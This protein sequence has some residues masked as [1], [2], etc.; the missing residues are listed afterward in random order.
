MTFL[1][2]SLLAGTALVALPIV[3]HLI[4]R[5][6]PRHLEFPALRFLETRRQTNQRQL[7]LRHLLLLALRVAAIFFLAAALA[8][9]SVKFSGALGSQ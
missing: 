2:A 5:R 8:R 4:M 1:N 6:K 9:P 7:R 3:L